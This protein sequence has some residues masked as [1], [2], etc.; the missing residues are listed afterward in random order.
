MQ[1]QKRLSRLVM[2]LLLAA[3]VSCATM[4]P[5]SQQADRER[6]V[7]IWMSLYDQQYKDTMSI[8]SSPTSTEGQKTIGRQK[9][10][11]LTEAWPL[12]KAYRDVVLAGGVPTDSSTQ[13]ITDVMNR[14]G[15]LAGGH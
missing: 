13:A 6:Q 10:A 15:R 1:M 3:L 8:M 11:I 2:V 12:L 4:P 7:E 5:V 9:T 14:L